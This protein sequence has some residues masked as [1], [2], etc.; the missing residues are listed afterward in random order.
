MELQRALETFDSYLQQERSLSPN[1]IR[2]YVGDL[3][4]LIRHLEAL[5]LAM[6]QGRRYRLDGDMEIRLRTLQARRDI[7]RTLNQRRFE[8][9]REITPLGREPVRGKVV[10]AGF[11]DEAGA[12]PFVIVR[13]RNGLEHYGRLRTGAERLECGRTITLAPMG[14]GLAQVVQGRGADLGR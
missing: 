7:I 14:N 1:T 2:A 6:R 9:G 11:H 5:G 13:D 4:S 3:E 12:A 10:K 8:G